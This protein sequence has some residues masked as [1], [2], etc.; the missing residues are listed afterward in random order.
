MEVKNPSPSVNLAAPGPIGGTTPA[1]ATF[2]TLTANTQLVIP[3]GYTPNILFSGSANTGIGGVDGN[4]VIYAGGQSF[5]FLSS[6]AYFSL[7]LQAAGGLVLGVP[8]VSMTP[9]VGGTIFN[10]Y[11]T[12]STTHTDGTEDD[13]YS[14]TTAAGAL[15]A[16]GASF[17]QTEQV[18]FVSSATAARRLKKYFGGTL[19]FDSG[20]LTLVAGGSFTLITTIIRESSTVV[21]CSVAVT[22]TS[23]STVPYTTYTRVTGLTLS[24][25][26]ILKTTGIASGTGA[27]SADISDLLEKTIWQAAA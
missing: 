25:T 1:A 4:V 7:Q 16:D 21:R 15:N 26:Q 12:V 5:Q 2:T 13:L 24:S 20:A 8:G 3:V 9:T 18:S 23:A 10:H 14:N 27:A 22:S 6:Y 11:T 19:I 17:Q